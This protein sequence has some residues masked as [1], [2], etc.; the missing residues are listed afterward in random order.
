M[1]EVIEG[2]DAFREQLRN[3]PEAF[4]EEAGPVVI[5]AATEAK[6]ELGAAYP[7]RQTGLRP[8]PHRKSPWYAPGG[9]K[10]RITVR[11]LSEGRFG[12]GAVVKNSAPHAWLYDNG[13]QARHYVTGSGKTHETGAMFEKR[14][15]THLF[16]K[17]V[18]RKRRE[19]YQALK[20]MVE[21]SNLT[22]SG[23]V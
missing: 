5:G 11:T 1:A 13:S 12:A 7:V 4:A 14:P 22:V 20:A 17:T 19:M 15:P 16:V 23:D 9:L 2:L 3:A 6:D 18:I 21:R 10:N 8:G